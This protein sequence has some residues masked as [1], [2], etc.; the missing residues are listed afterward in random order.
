MRWLITL[1]LFAFV[2]YKAGLFSSDSR[3]QFLELLTQA[4]ILMLCLS[5]LIGILVN[6]CSA[7]K[8]WLLVKARNI[9]AGLFRIFAYYLVGQ[10][11]NLLLPTS[12][13]GDV[14]RAYELGKF[15][16]KKADALASVFVERYTGVL[17]LLL[18]SFIAFVLKLSAFN[19][20]FVIWSLLA[21]AL[22][23]G[24]MG[25][26]ILEPKVFKW[27]RRISANRFLVIDK[28]L[29]KLDK[30]VLSIGQYKNEKAAIVWAFINSLVFYFMAIVNIYVTTLVFQMDV[31]FLDIVIAT[32]I[33]M[34]IMNIPLSIGNLGIMEFAY[35]AVFQMM[36]YSPALGLSVALLMRLKSLLDGAMGGVLHPV[37][38]TEKG[39]K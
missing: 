13:G 24:V 33:I 12:V 21:F 2:F 39:R 4:N 22:V 36:G 35:T 26:M 32:P 5:V 6:V 8:W 29:S 19:Q 17:V 3:N 34:L 28:V 9:Q 15:S 30:L 1:A 23:L 37:S 31:S 14:V 20:Q 16:N 10:F 25:W 18:L 11:Y 27:F 38:V 7:I